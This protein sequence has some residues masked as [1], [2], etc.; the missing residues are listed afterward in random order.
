[1]SD[2]RHYVYKDGVGKTVVSLK[3]EINVFQTELSTFKPTTSIRPQ[4]RPNANVSPAE[5][6]AHI[7]GFR[8]LA[9]IVSR[10]G[11]ASSAHVITIG[12]TT[13]TEIA[14]FSAKCDGKSDTN[15]STTTEN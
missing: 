8:I 10:T 12:A 11:H 2:V 4:F 1:M 7:G 5:L 3:H 13:T 14:T 6:V 9:V 15:Q